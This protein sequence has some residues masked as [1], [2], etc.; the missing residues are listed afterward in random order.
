MED[1]GLRA[2]LSWALQFHFA[3]RRLYNIVCEIGHRTALPFG[4]VI[5][6]R[7]QMPFDGG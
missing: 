6:R 5:E 3:Q 7:D 2:L 1:R 4:F